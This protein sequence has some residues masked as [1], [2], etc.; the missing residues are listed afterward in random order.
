MD[1]NEFLKNNGAVFE[2]GTVVSFG[3][4]KRES[5]ACL[6]K[7]SIADLSQFTPV[8]ITGKDADSF[9]HGQFAGDI[10]SLGA[11]DYLLTAWCNPK[12]QVIVN[13]YILRINDRF[14]LLVPGDLCEKFI[15]RLEMF[16]LRAEVEVTD[17]RGELVSIGININE[18]ANNLPEDILTGQPVKQLD[19]YTCLRNDKDLPRMIFT[20]D[21]KSISGLWQTLSTNMIPVGTHQWQMLDIQAGIPWINEQSTEQFLPQYLNLD[22]LN[23][24][25]FDKGCFPGQEIVARLK[26]RGVVKQRLY[27]A[28]IQ[29]ET[30]PK[31]GDNLSLVNEDRNAGTIVNVQPHPELGFIFLAVAEIEHASSGNIKLKATGNTPTFHSLPYSVDE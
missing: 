14:L 31:P 7:N 26:Y 13:F 16:I 21:L 4:T 10:K 5:G 6:D 2:N 19:G 3:N 12:G 9:L 15:R 28:S 29:Q 17:K 8:E 20:G 22:F 27:L 24:V 25:S 1:W 30:V 23:G 18:K 11:N